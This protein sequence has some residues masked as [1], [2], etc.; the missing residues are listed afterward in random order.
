[1]EDGQIITGDFFEDLFSKLVEYKK[2]VRADFVGFKGV[3]DEMNTF[4][5]S[6][7]SISDTMKHTSEEISEDY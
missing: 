2:V 1:V 5:D 4:A 3:T 7:N 6:I